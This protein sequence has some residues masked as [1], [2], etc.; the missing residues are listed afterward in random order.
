MLNRYSWYL[1]LKR[2]TDFSLPLA[3]QQAAVELTLPGSPQ[4][5]RPV[6]AQLH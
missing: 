4:V 6:V 1:E 5:T 2:P 3:K